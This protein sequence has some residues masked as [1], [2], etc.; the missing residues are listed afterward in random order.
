MQVPVHGMLAGN[1]VGGKEAQ[2]RDV[3]TVNGGTE[4]ALDGLR[5]Q[6]AHLES[7]TEPFGSSVVR[8]LHQMWE[9]RQWQGCEAESAVCAGEVG[10]AEQVE[11]ATGREAP[12]E[13]ALARR[14]GQH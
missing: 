10:A 6:R 5:K 7:N 14:G 9:I 13:G 1:Q 2:G 11:K 12:R 3:Q 4:G 8:F